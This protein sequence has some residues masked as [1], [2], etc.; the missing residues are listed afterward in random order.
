MLVFKL[1]GTG[2]EVTT[3][4]ESLTF[5]QGLELEAQ[6]GMGV[7]KYQSE[8][9]DGTT[10]ASAAL[11]WIAAVN[12]AAARDHVSF[13]DAARVLTFEKFGEGLDLMATLRRP[14]APE[15]PT[16]ATPDGSPTPT[17]PATSEPPPEASPS[18]S[19]EPVTS[20]SSPTTSGSAPGS[21]TA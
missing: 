15:D 18:P 5:A 13:R 16:G 19:P 20:D 6:T 17:S 10:R 3:D 12:E 2:D 4:E 8:L 14:V 21:G 7:G 1:N 11:F 9:I